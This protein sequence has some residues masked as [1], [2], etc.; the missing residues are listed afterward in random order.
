VTT[1]TRTPVSVIIPAHDEERVIGRCL[2]TLTVG[3]D[4]GELEVVVVCN[5]C[6]DRTA[7]VARAALV[8]GRVLELPRPSKSDALNAGDA[9]ATRFPRFYVDADIEVSIEAVRATAQV[10]AGDHVLCAAPHPRFELAGRSWMIRAFYDTWSRLPYMNNE[11]VGTGVYALSARGRA[12]FTEFPDITADDQFVLQQFAV[13]E[14]WSLRDHEFSVFPPT[15]LGGLL[16]MRRR[17]YRGV[18]E[19]ARYGT[20]HTPPAGRRARMLEL[21]RRPARIP[22]LAV[23][24]AVVVTARIW[25]LLMPE[26]KRWERDDSGR[27]AARTP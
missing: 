10:L 23:Y 27:A 21:A 11:V 22:G 1:A 2:E 26:P 18:R 4:P 15:S 25:A 20:P 14:R 7:T 12:R 6:A 8:D 17:A 3:A 19:L 13:E 24:L 16:K 9:I 5:G